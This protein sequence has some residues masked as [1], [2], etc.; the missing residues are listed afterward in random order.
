MASA[1]PPKPSVVAE[2]TRSAAAFARA[3]PVSSA[4]RAVP[5]GVAR[6]VAT[7]SRMRETTSSP[8]PG[9]SV[10]SS[11]ASAPSASAQ[12]IGPRRPT[13][14]ESPPSPTSVGISPAT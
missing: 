5:A 13:R 12:A 3:S 6:P 2:V 1:P 7:P 8:Q 14:S 9:D 4:I 11:V 10:G